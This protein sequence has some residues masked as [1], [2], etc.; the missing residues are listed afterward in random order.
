MSSSLDHV[1]YDR[2]NLTDKEKEDLSR[3]F[4]DRYDDEPEKL[5]EFLCDSDFS[6]KNLEF[7]DSWRFIEQKLNSLKRYTNIRHAILRPDTK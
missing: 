3:E 1:L 2:R 6:L 5:L 7:F 4:Q